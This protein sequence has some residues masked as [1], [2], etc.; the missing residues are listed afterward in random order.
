MSRG[1]QSENVEDKKEKGIYKEGPADTQW[2]VLSR[3]D[4]SIEVCD[5]NVPNVAENVLF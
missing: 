4:G 5:T 3:E 1:R 2:C